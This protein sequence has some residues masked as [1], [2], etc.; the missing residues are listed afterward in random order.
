MMRRFGKAVLVAWA[1]TLGTGAHAQGTAGEVRLNGEDLS[2]LADP[3]LLISGELV[4]TDEWIRVLFLRGGGG[5]AIYTFTS[6][7]G[8]NYKGTWRIDGDAICWTHPLLGE[9]CRHYYR[10][11]DGTYEGRSVTEG[12]TQLKF[13]IINRQQ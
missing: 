11:T 3:S 5:Y 7:E 10:L 4:G 2:K 9:R 8:G 6:G 12:R 1:L 13:R